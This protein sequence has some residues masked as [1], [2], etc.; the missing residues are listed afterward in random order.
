MRIMGAMDRIVDEIILAAL[1]LPLLLAAPPSPAKVAALLVALVAV[2]ALELL[3]PRR[4]AQA[5][6]ATA[7]L[8]AVFAVPS[9]AAFVPLIAYVAVAFSL[10][11]LRFLWPVSALA[12]WDAS[13]ILAAGALC[14]GPSPA[15]WPGARGPTARNA[16]GCG[17]CATTC[18]KSTWP[19]PPAPATWPSAR[20]WK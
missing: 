3:A 17:A 11:P 12:A 8:A 15:S 14:W 9:L 20:I 13:G 1:G 7:L 18:R 4:R 10:G 16:T 19:W 2:G 5:A 6:V